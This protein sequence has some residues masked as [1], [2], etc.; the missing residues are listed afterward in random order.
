MITA[1][2]QLSVWRSY[3]SRFFK[4]QREAKIRRAYN[5]NRGGHYYDYLY[6]DMRN[7]LKLSYFILC[8]RLDKSLKHGISIN[9][10]SFEDFLSVIVNTMIMHQTTQVRRKKPHVSFHLL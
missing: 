5:T 2:K 10:K 6:E 8:Q 4:I 1:H 9:H 3:I 7:A